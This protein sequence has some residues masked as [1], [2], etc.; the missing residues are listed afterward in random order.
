MGPNGFGVEN[1]RVIGTVSVHGSK[2]FQV[3]LFPTSSATNVHFR[4]CYT[5][6]FFVQLIAAQF[7]I[8]IAQ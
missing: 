2:R 3:L 6:Q 1:A 8:K 7:A 4:A 5:R